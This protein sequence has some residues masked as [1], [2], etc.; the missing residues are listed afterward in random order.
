MRE[1]FSI[2]SLL[3]HDNNALQK[4]PFYDQFRVPTIVK[5]GNGWTGTHLDD[6]RLFCDST[7]L[8]FAVLQTK[9]CNTVCSTE[10]SIACGTE[11]STACSIKYS[12]ACSA[13]NQYCGTTN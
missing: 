12:I 6:T 5:Y 13:I 1:N 9:I 4:S 3:A 7:K 10:C 8:P 2:I 11:C